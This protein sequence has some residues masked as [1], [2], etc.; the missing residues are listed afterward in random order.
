MVAKNE[1][2]SC[3][4]HHPNQRPKLKNPRNPVNPDSKPRLQDNTRLSQ[5]LIG[6]KM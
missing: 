6:N 1:F 3:G 5:R 4:T 2:K